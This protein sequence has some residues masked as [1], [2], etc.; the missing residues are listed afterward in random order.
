MN[1]FELFAKLS[2][3]TGNFDS[4]LDKA[5]K[6]VDGFGNAAKDMK[7]DSEKADAAV[8]KMAD[9][10]DD[11]GTEAKLHASRRGQAI[12]LYCKPV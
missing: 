8:D 9:A 10:I 6:S 4:D 7:S 3:D 1:V 11:A 12:G 5:A 2:V